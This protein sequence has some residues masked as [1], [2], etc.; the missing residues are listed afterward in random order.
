MMLVE[1]KI[2]GPGLIFTGQIRQSPT[3]TFAGERGERGERGRATGERRMR[4]AR[5][6]NTLQFPAWSFQQA[7]IHG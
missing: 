6:Y 5:I 1:A 3:A 7:T 4:T 2:H